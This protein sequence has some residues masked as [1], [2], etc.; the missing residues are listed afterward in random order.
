MSVYIEDF[1][2]KLIMK[3]I[4]EIYLPCDLNVFKCT[5]LREES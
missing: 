5:F 2:M 3:L 1:Y 4:Y